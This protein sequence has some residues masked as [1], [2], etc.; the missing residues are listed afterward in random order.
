GETPAA[1]PVLV[2]DHA[3]EPA[4]RTRSRDA[5]LEAGPVAQLVVNEAGQ[6]VSANRRARD[7]FDLASTDVGRPFRDLDL[8][9]RPLE[10][11]SLMDQARE[12][13]RVV[14]AREVPW[15]R[16]PETRHFDVEVVGLFDASGE[17]IGASVSFTDVS[18]DHA[19]RVE[20]EHTNQELETAMEELQSTNEELETTNEELQSTNEELETTNEDV[21]ATVE[22]ELQATNRRGQPIRC[23]V[24]LSALRGPDGVSRGVILL[25]E[26]ASR[27]AGAPA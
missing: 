1:P 4:E 25:M 17:R 24:N 15:R 21:R 9:Y 16:G 19:L 23:R 11:R 13:G 8:S 6:L 20:L 26:A 10:L 2:E 18:R 3:V 12:E 5:A 14:L 27:E 7:L 22:M